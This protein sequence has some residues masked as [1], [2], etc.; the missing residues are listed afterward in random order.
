MPLVPKINKPEPPRP[1]NTMIVCTRGGKPLTE[2]DRQ[3]LQDF[4][5]YRKAR[6]LKGKRHARNQIRYE[7]QDCAIIPEKT[8]KGGHSQ[9]IAARAFR[10]IQYC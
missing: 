9:A 1:A 7:P 6:A 5:E 4:I 10:V 8:A 3:A 2:T